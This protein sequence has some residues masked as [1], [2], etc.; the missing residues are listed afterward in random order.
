M[1]TARTMTLM[2]E[3]R[4]VD[5]K[6]ENIYLNHGE[7]PSEKMTVPVTASN[8]TRQ[9]TK[10]DILLEGGER[11][12]FN[13]LRLLLQLPDG[14]ELTVRVKTFGEGGLF[15]KLAK[16]LSIK[17]PEQKFQGKMVPD[18][19]VLKTNKKFMK[20]LTEK[21]TELKQLTS[22]MT[23]VIS[24]EFKAPAFAEDFYLTKIF[25]PEEI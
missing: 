1:K 12:E 13:S 17:I 15:W 24:K 23:V 6:L 14:R 11:D 5:L 10:V 3:N 18:Y 20:L 16:N 4:K 7:I 19:R 22:I 8:F 2:S 25:A 9:L 21:L